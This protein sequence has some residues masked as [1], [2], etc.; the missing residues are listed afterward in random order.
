MSPI[1]AIPAISSLQRPLCRMKLPRCGYKGA[2]SRGVG[3]ILKGQPSDLHG[4]RR[5]QFFPVVVNDHAVSVELSGKLL[6]R[7][8][9]GAVAWRLDD[10]TRSRFVRGG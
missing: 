9:K 3:I 6:S 1:P 8:T 4:Q 7:R 10:D 2:A 5:I